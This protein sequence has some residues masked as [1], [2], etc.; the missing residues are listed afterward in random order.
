[1]TVGGR[2]VWVGRGPGGKY[3]TSPG[4]GVFGDSGNGTGIISGINARNIDVIPKINASTRMIGLEI[5]EDTTM[6]KILNPP[7]NREINIKTAPNTK[8]P[9]TKFSGMMSPRLYFPVVS[10]NEVLA[11]FR[12]S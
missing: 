2:L 5:E 6:V 9:M 7:P 4:E 3:T 11:E 1:M 12:A 10:I 8:R